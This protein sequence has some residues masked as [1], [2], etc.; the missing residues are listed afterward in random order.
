MIEPAI[1]TAG[2]TKRFGD[3]T[4]VD[5]VD[6]EMPRGC[7]FGF[8]GPNGAGKTRRGHVI[9]ARACV[10]VEQRQYER[11]KGA[12]TGELSAIGRRGCLGD[13]ASSVC[14]PRVSGG[15]QRR[16]GASSTLFDVLSVGSLG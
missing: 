8:L 4:V 6:L 1:Q 12:F 9:D 14:L 10:E 16:G 5:G 13:P 7:A 15:G 3:R 2:L 11:I